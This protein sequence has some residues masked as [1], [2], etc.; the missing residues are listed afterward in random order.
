MRYLYSNSRSETQEIL[1]DE[2]AIKKVLEELGVTDVPDVVVKGMKKRFGTVGRDDYYSGQHCAWADLAAELE[3]VENLYLWAPRSPRI[4]MQ[5][6]SLPPYYVERRKEKGTL[7]GLVKARAG[8]SRPFYRITLLHGM[9]GVGKT[10]LAKAMVL[11]KRVQ[12]CFQDPIQ[13][14]DLAED[15]TAEDCLRWLLARLKSARGG[16]ARH[17]AE[18]REE[19][20]EV[21]SK[22]KQS[23]LFVLN[24][25]CRRSNR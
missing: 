2:E 10:T 20:R 3:R 13:W 16:S 9:A 21:L 18:V 11:D 1:R 7:E 8:K 17:F 14:I 4:E 25:V 5:V 19:I 24:G 23:V 22:T 12:S 15:H 6:G